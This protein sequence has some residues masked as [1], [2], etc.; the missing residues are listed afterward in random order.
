M[1]NQEIKIEDLR[2]GDEVLIGSSMG[3][4][5]V[6]ILRPLKKAKKPDW[7]GNI[8]YSS[9]KCAVNETIQKYTIPR[10]NYIYTKK[11]CNISDDAE[12]NK[13]KHI[14]FNYKNIYLLK[15]AEQW[16]ND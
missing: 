12:Y 7:Y 16:N 2:V 5:R 10:S 14:N 6:K 8:P 4:T 13:E 15:R 11:F 1:E 3:L 9:V